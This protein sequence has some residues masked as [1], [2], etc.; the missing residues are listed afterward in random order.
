MRRLLP[1]ILISLFL[2]VTP[3][4]YSSEEIPDF[5]PES[6]ITAPF[7]L[8]A[9]V[10]PLDL[11]TAEPVIAALVV[12]V[13]YSSTPSSLPSDLLFITTSLGRAPPA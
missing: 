9:A 13:G 12:A 7:A 1:S 6:P 3:I 2:L 5:C 4:S 11:P 8:R 10:A